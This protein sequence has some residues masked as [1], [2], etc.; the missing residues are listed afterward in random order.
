[1]K[2]NIIIA[3]LLVVLM[4]A[5][6]LVGCYH[7]KPTTTTTTN[8]T[9]TTTTT[10]PPATVRYTVTEEEW[11]HWTTYPNYTIEQ[12]YGDELILNKYTEDA[13]EFQDGNIILFIGDKQYSLNETDD[14]YVAH[15]VTFMEFSHGGLLRGGYIYDEFTYNED[16]FAYVLDLIAEEGIYC[17]VKFEDGVPVS[18]LYKEY[19]DGVEALVVRS[20]YLNVGTTVIDIPEYVFEEED[21]TRYTVTEEEW[22]LNLSVGN[23]SGIITNFSEDDPTSI[24][25]KCTN[26]AIELAGMLVVFEGD[27]MYQ[28][29]ELEGVWYAVELE[30]G[31]GIPTMVPQGL[32]FS[33]Y[34]YDEERKMYVPKVKTGAELYYS[35]LFVDGALKHVCLQTTLDESNPEYYELLSFNIDEIGTVEIEIPEYQFS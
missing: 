26:N 21:T 28:L 10:N 16:L 12:Y 5:M 9:T 7:T 4:S 23:Y 24:P 14:G 18:I 22:N 27:K 25:Y 35:F 34:E 20:N 19:K 32:N 15:D 3:I 2:R 30:D 31:L 1:M 33:D 8:T 6:I 13:L 29:Q 17:E 11:N